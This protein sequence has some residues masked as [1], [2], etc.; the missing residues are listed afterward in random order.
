M[1][2]RQYL[3]EGTSSAKPRSQE[4]GRLDE[5][6]VGSGCPPGAG[7]ELETSLL[8]GPDATTILAVHCS[9]AW[10]TSSGPEMEESMTGTSF[11]TGRVQEPE[12]VLNSAERALPSAP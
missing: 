1:T 3:L 8:K 6:G 2:A 9:L 12:Q 7:L 10:A 11:T 5:R 4:K